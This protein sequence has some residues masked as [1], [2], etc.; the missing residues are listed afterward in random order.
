MR[1][2]SLNNSKFLAI[3]IFCL[4]NLAAI[5]ESTEITTFELGGASNS[6]GIVNKGEFIIEEDLFH[7][8]DTFSGKNSYAF[9][10]M[11]TKLRYGLL[12]KRLEARLTTA[13]LALNPIDSGL[14]NISLGTKI[15]FLNESKYL[16]STEL[17]AD[18]EIPVGDRDLRNPGFE[19][20]YMLVLGKAWTKKFGSIVNLSADFASFR[21]ETG[22]GGIVSMPMVFN[23]N[24]YFKPE[25][26]VFSHIYGTH[27]FTGGIDDPLSVDLGLSYALTKD[28]V[29]I[30]W[31]SKGLND[32]A[33]DITVDVGLVY[34]P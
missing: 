23:I 19:Q 13:G 33:Q 21:S 32:A 28:F 7:Y 11:Q 6:P 10:L 27:Y 25:L 34:R 22:V 29:F 2:T 17:I 20:S 16:P 24:Y 18:W 9:Q 14:S 3:I 31:V 30:S 1:N 5:A 15:R 8:Q 4:A 26:N 12:Q